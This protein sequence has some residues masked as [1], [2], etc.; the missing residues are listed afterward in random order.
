MAE[1]PNPRIAAVLSFVFSGLGQIYNGQIAKG[2]LIIAICTAG[3]LAIIIGSVLIGYWLM[4]ES[5]DKQGLF[6]GFALFLSGIIMV[7]ILGIYSI[8]DAYRFAKKS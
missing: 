1:A 8:F 5:V 7:V 3:M 4:F 6:I 2:L